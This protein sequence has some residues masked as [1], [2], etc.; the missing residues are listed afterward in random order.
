MTRRIDDPPAVRIRERY[1]SAPRVRVPVLVREPAGR[2]VGEMLL[3]VGEGNTNRV[4]AKHTEA[5]GRPTSRSEDHE[6][7]R[8]QTG[9]LTTAFCSRLATRHN[10]R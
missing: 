6:K 5:P 3:E 9:R 1:G 7:L 10:R 4:K 8:C 2:A